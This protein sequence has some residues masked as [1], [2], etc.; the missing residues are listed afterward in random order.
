MAEKRKFKP[1]V[2]KR[3]RVNDRTNWSEGSWADT[4]SSRL[5]Q[6]MDPA[7]AE[8]DSI[9]AWHAG[10]EQEQALQPDYG[11]LMAPQDMARGVGQYAA[12]EAAAAVGLD[13][14]GLLMS[15][16][17]AVGVPPEYALAAAGGLLGGKALR[18]AGKAAVKEVKAG[19][20][21]ASNVSTDAILNIRALDP[22]EAVRL[23]RKGTHLKQDASGQYVG[24][25]RGVN[26]PA[27][28]AAWRRDL[29]RQLE[30][31]ARVVP[32]AIDWYDRARES[33]VRL[34]GPDPQ[35]QFETARN[36]SLYSAQRAPKVNLGLSLAAEDAYAVGKRAGVKGP[37]NENQWQAYV[38]GR[39]PGKGIRL[40]PKTGEYGNK[41]DPTFRDF[42]LNKQGGLGER[43]P[44]GTRSERS[45]RMGGSTNDIWHFRF[46]GYTGPDGG[47][48]KAGGTPQMHAF[49][50]AE[51]LLAAERANA[52]KL[53]GRSDWNMSSVQA[54]PWV[55]KKGEDLFLRKKEAK[56]LEEGY[57]MAA[58]EYREHFPKYTAH[59]TD[60]SMVAE[61]A[62]HLPNLKNM[63]EA[64]RRAY[65][66][67]KRAIWTNPG[68]AP[69]ERRDW[70]FDNA[71]KSQLPVREATGSY[72]PTGG[73]METNAVDVGSPLVSMTPGAPVQYVDPKTNKIMDDRD[74]GV[75]DDARDLLAGHANLVGYG[76]VQ[77][78]GSW[79]MP[80]H[81]AKARNKGGLLFTTDGK[82]TPEQ[83]AEVSAAGK[84]AGLPDVVDYQ[85]KVLFTRFW[86]EDE[87]LAANSE[88]RKKAT[89]AIEEAM[90]RVGYKEIA[91]VRV[92]SGLENFQDAWPAA[93]EGQGLATGQFLRR[94][95]ET[96][97]RGLLDTPA[98]ASRMGAERQ[99]DDAFAAR[100]A[101]PARADI[102]NARGIM[103]ASDKPMTSL[104]S[105]Y[106]MNQQI[107]A[108]GRAAGLPQDEINRRLKQ[109]GVW[110]P[111]FGLLGAGLSQ[112]QEQQAPSPFAYY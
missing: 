6:R 40:G 68:N 77:N 66:E 99:V 84:A 70:F 10:K 101:G 74:R 61:G 57:A 22:K 76:R 81:S 46:L 16:A 109:A 13:P 75:A 73:K 29:D 8:R 98:L 69:G 97:T 24:A 106:D 27:K 65:H 55:Y 38:E 32:A 9:A 42:D 7:G 39:E 56:S 34:A 89:P 19:R 18:K 80:I 36:L 33:T 90:G 59:T 47:K 102:Q 95:D 20:R 62:G 79:S 3:V 112:Q 41:F 12:G 35:R 64:D 96:R 83:M 54:L 87:G 51:T 103:E 85:D 50:D 71:N 5:R 60:E 1:A 37:G 92:D 31:A 67:A 2:Q 94:A 110:L 72:T 43:L 105:A 28:L 53:G 48:F 25:P 78:G 58:Q 15:G 93:N 11:L 111:A 52:R 23:V 107:Q 91:P 86:D 4:V 45:K 26:S 14:V 17:D 44:A 88:L 108:Q 21:A 30:D 49:A 63:S 100:G 82:L 104:Q